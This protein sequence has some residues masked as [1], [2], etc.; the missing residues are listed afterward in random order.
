MWLHGL[1]ERHHNE[2]TQVVDRPLL[3]AMGAGDQP[4][5][6]LAEQALLSV[7]EW[8]RGVG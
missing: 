3:D 8:L 4:A 2:K 6:E 1:C 5:A 7:R